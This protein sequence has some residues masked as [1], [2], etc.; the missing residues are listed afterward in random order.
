MWCAIALTIMLTGG[1]VLLWTVYSDLRLPS[2]TSLGV[3]LVVLGFAAAL[4]CLG[5]WIAINGHRGPE[6]GP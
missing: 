5:L 4:V 2:F 3:A 1:G 6:D